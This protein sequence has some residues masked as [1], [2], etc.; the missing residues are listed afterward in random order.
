[1]GRPALNEAPSHHQLCVG[2][3][4]D[5]I[6]RAALRQQ[7]PNQVSCVVDDDFTRDVWAAADGSRA[8]GRAA[9]GS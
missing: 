7:L 5:L 3:P 6:E 4:A 8:W 2:A 9:V 1:M